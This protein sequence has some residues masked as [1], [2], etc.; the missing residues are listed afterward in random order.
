MRLLT[1]S[2]ALVI[3][4]SGCPVAPERTDIPELDLKAQMKLV[5]LGEGDVF[6]VRVYN[7]KQL[8]GIHRVSP[9]GDIDF[10]LIG[11]VA[12]SGKTAS[13]VAKLIREKLEGGYLT[14][15]H[16]SVFV[17]EHSSKRV[18]VIG[19]VKKPGTFKYRTGLSIVEG[20]T[21]AQGFSGAANKS[22]VVITRKNRGGKDKRFFLDVAAIQKGEQDNFLLHAGDIVFV[23]DRLL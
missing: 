9:Q 19:Q 4:M 16:V 22:Y 12:V 18:Y 23:P 5:G 17:K 2:I 10:P 7:E 20:I 13:V 14:S 1:A 15:A 3:V 6:E 11:A 8:S 21:M